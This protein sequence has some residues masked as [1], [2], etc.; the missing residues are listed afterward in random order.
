MNADRDAYSS[1]PILPVVKIGQNLGVFTQSTYRFYRVLHIEPFPATRQTT[2]DFGAVN[3]AASSTQQEVTVINAMEGSLQH[4]RC[5]VLDDIELEIAQIRAS[6]R[7]LAN[8]VQARI[9]LYTQAHDPYLATTTLFVLGKDKPVF[10]IATNRTGYNLL[11]SRVVFF[12]FR[13]ILDRL[14]PLQEKALQ[15]LT[16]NTAGELPDTDEGVRM[17]TMLAKGLTATIVPAEGRG[18]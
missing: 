11:Q 7:F 14:N 5:F 17:K 1:G 2:F 8:T 13:Y 18:A 15:A 16:L 10:G 6:G 12:G 3:T 9:T 4:V